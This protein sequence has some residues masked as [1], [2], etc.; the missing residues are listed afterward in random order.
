MI[1]LHNLLAA[2]A[3]ITVLDQLP[4]ARREEI[5]IKAID[6]VPRPKEQ[7][8]LGIMTWEL[9]LEAGQKAEVRFGYNIEHP[10]ELRVVGIPD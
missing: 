2:T 1:R 6:A 4:H 9:S 5:K 8:E 3:K 10:R 7:T